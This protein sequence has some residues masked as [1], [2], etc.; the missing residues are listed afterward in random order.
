MLKKFNEYFVQAQF[1]PIKS[2]YLKNDLNR[3]VWDDNDKLDGSVVM[4][5]MIN[6]W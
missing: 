6:G 3:D 1:E 4:M 2:F 5:I